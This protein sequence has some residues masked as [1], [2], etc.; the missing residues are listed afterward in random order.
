MNEVVTFTFANDA[1]SGCVNSFSLSPEPRGGVDWGEAR[2]WLG[3]DCERLEVTTKSPPCSLSKFIECLVPA[4][5]W[6]WD[7][8]MSSSCSARQWGD[9]AW[10]A[11]WLEFH[12]NISRNWLW[13]KTWMLPEKVAVKGS[14]GVIWPTI[15]LP[16]PLNV[17]TIPSLVWSLGWEGKKGL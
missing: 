17:P 14:E 1:V 16:F 6:W 5:P 8:R 4:A 2:A 12:S 15:R 9:S 10:K 11:D 7:Q 3:L 13:S